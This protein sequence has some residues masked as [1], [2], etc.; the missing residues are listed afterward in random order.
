MAQQQVSPFPQPPVGVVRPPQEPLLYVLPKLFD[1]TTDRGHRSYHSVICRTEL[2]TVRLRGPR[3]Y[4]LLHPSWCPK[5]VI[6]HLGIFA[7]P[8]LVS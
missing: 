1:E 2:G 6:R 8:H 3:H 4:M 7:F 5:Y